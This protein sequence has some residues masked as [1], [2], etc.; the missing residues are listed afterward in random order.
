VSGGTSTSQPE[1]TLDLLARFSAAQVRTGDMDPVYPILRQLNAA[2]GHGP[3]EPEALRRTLMYVALY[4]VAASEC[5]LLSE[6]WQ[7]WETTARQLA[8]RA[9]V[10]RRG[11]RTPDFLIKHL[12]YIAEQHHAHGKAGLRGWLQWDWNEW[13]SPQDRWNKVSATAMDVP[14]NG[15]W[16]AYKLCDVLVEVNGWEMEAPDAGHRWSSG[17][18]EGLETLA[19]QG[20]FSD[21]PPHADQSNEAIGRLDAATAHVQ[22]ELW[23]RGVPLKISEVETVL[24]NWKALSR[25]RYYTGHDID[26]LLGAVNTLPQSGPYA[27]V[28]SSL[29][30]ARRASFHPDLLG[31]LSGAWIGVRKEMMPVF[32]ATGQLVNEEVGA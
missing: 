10:E 9:G 24:C 31:E 12:T 5:V 11:L 27:P 15:R 22:R 14:F 7:P 30:A 21:L 25:G 16:A 8:G 6:G 26:E 1:E 13:L 17:P 28:R 19:E 18:R 20:V 2:D 23:A 3:G 32:A 29:L 4:N